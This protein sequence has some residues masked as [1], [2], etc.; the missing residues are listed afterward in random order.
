MVSFCCPVAKRLRT[1]IVPLASRIAGQ[2]KGWPGSRPGF[3]VREKRQTGF[4]QTAGATGAA[5][6]LLVSGS[7]GLGPEA[8]AGRVTIAATATRPTMV[9]LVT[10]RDRGTRD[11]KHLLLENTSVDH[12]GEAL[13]LVCQEGRS[14]AVAARRDKPGHPE[15][16]CLVAIATDPDTAGAGGRSQTAR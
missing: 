8:L 15:G 11:M 16:H 5:A 7:A 13:G 3:T 1:W 12:H 9:D 10:R 14:A 4:V 6:T 2:A